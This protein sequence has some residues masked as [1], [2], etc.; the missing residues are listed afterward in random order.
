MAIKWSW[1]NQLSALFAIAMGKL[2]IVAFL[3]HLHGPEDRW[4]VAILWV[5]ALSSLVINVI[6]IIIVL[7]QCH[8]LSK[9]WDDKLAGTCDYLRTHNSAFFQGSMISLISK[10]IWESETNFAGII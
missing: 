3:Q 6:I 5:V 4:K 2:A 8:P 9:L 10:I 1:V 7:T